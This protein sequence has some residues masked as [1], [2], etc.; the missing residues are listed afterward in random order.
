MSLGQYMKFQ[1]DKTFSICYS[2]HHNYHETVTLLLLL[3]N[4]VVVIYIAISI[5]SSHQLDL[6]V[7]HQ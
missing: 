3:L 4:V 5:I 7:Y 6:I 2:N 1:Y